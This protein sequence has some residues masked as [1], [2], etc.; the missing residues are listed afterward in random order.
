[1]TVKKGQVL[2][3]TGRP[4]G[5]ISKV[6]SEIKEVISKAVKWIND[7][8]RFDQIMSDVAESK[9]EV[10]INFLAKVAPKD[11]NIEV[12]EKKENPVLQNIIAMRKAIEQQKPIEMG[13]IKK[14]GKES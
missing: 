5:A 7:P 13:D 9:P 11:L 12:G 8:E 6:N 10:L 4:K 2:N 1:M 14:D 3:P